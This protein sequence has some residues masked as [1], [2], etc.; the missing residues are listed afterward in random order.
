MK[1]SLILLIAVMVTAVFIVSCGESDKT[2]LDQYDFESME[3][4]EAIQDSLSLE[5]FSPNEWVTIIKLNRDEERNL[6]IALSDI[7]RR[8]IFS[9]KILD[10]E[11]RI[12]CYN[13]RKDNSG[14]YKGSA[15][16]YPSFASVESDVF[17]LGWWEYQRGRRS[18]HWLE[19]EKK[20]TEYK[21]S[22][23]GN[24]WSYQKGEVQVR[25]SS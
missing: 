13:R 24:P 10:C 22:M 21:R 16:C 17:I 6:Q 11:F 4:S 9:R 19:I 1:K 23:Y 15:L 25:L 3:T 5:G 7:G 14:Y 18:E 12:K 8:L 2:P 20:D